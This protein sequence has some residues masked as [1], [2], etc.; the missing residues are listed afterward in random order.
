MEQLRRGRRL[1]GNTAVSAPVGS[2]PGPP[3]A[4]AVAPAT[5][6]T[7]PP[8]PRRPSRTKRVLGWIAASLAVVLVLTTIG[9][10]LVYRHLNGNITHYDAAGQEIIKRPPKLNKAQNI[11][12]IGSDTRAFSGGAAFGKE[13]GGA[14]SD[15]T[16]LVHLS[17]GGGK[18]V[19]VSI[20]RDSYVMLPPCRTPGGGQS[21]AHMDKFN[22]AYSIGGPAC[23][24]ATVESLTHIH[25]DHFVEVNFQ[26]FQ[27]MVNALG[28]VNV[29]IS[30]PINDPIRF[31][32]GHYEG[33]GLVLPAGTSKLNG[34]QSL[35]FVRA[36]Y[37]VGDGSDIGRIKDQQLFIS[38]VI[39]KATSAGLLVD[40]PALY[41][42]LDAATK[43]IRTDPHFGLSQLKN[44]ADRL[45]GLKPGAVQLLTI[46]FLYNAP[47]VPSADIGWDPVK[48]PAVW[49]ALRSD[50]PLPGTAT[51]PAP[52]PSASATG[53]ANPLTVPPSA[54]YVR[55]LNGTGEP[56]IAHQVAA[57][58]E[59]EGFHATAGNA[60]TRGYQTTVVRYGSSRQESSQTLAA[61]VKGSTRELDPSLGTTVQLVIGTQFGGVVPVSVATPPAS[62]SPSPSSSLDVVTAEQNLCS[63]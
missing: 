60:A 52:R 11:L 40:V 45:H 53:G 16:I 51:A 56:G 14:R 61:A 1:E 38:A 21:T 2:Q 37:G 42:F 46:P 30:K 55:V 5:P 48:A 17:A 63:S 4:P 47:G 57:Q 13:V 59:A 50:K 62:P 49:T 58:L 18:A 29:C 34:K 25:I 28:G 23:T 15:T 31:V 54:I 6:P 12:L 22:A 9:G 44:L 19:L 39:R 33:S 3:T 35:A 26:G 24:I 8:G 27:R 43:S 20:P 41:R 32:S 10:Y 36:R 7:R